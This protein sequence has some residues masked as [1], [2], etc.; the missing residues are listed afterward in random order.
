MQSVSIWILAAGEFFF[1]DY[2]ELFV[3]FHNKV[4][5]GGERSS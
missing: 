1:F 4:E 5:R 3:F 2:L